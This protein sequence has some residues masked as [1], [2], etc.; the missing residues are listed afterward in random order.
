MM[1]ISYHVPPNSNETFFKFESAAAFAMM[2]PTSVEPVK[3]TFRISGC[4]LIAP[5]AVGPY[6]GTTYYIQI[7]T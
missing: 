3:A 7:Y 6:P 2:R 4:E 1:C 5:P